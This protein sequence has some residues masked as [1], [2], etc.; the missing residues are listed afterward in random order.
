[1][2]TYVS[3]QQHP[4]TLPSQAHLV[5]QDWP[6]LKA[7]ARRQMQMSHIHVDVTLRTSLVPKQEL[8]Y[9][10]AEYKM[11]SNLTRSY[12]GPSFKSNHHVQ[13]SSRYGLSPASFLL[14]LISFTSRSHSEL[15]DLVLDYPVSVFSLTKNPATLY[16]SSFPTYHVF[17]QKIIY[18]LHSPA[19]L[20]LYRLKPT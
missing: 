13:A 6:W 9:L 7:G 17:F 2:K 20:L 12:R 5:R 11:M 19:I 1:M 15:Q 4:A 10:S 14:Y 18:S 3:K 16:N 8:G